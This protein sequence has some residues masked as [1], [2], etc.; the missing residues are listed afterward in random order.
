[1][2]EL[3][4]WVYVIGGIIAWPICA[5]F[6]FDNDELFDDDIFGAVAMRLVAALL[7]PFIIPGIFVAKFI[8]VGKG[9][10]KGDV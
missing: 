4:G 8:S 3:L 7:W 10:E 6:V 9:N 5:K 1:M 2:G